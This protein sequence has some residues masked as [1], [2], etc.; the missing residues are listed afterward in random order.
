MEEVKGVVQ[1]NPLNLFL[2][3]SVAGTGHYYPVRPYEAAGS[4]IGLR[5]HIC[6]SRS[7]HPQASLGISK[8]P[9]IEGT[10]QAIT[11]T[12]SHLDRCSFQGVIM[13][14]T[15]F[16]RSIVHSAKTGRTGLPIWPLRLA[17]ARNLRRRSL[18]SS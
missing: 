18:A 13:M 6:S 2:T 8:R 7:L 15:P 3:S 12:I 11:P 9:Q 16:S 17:P 14:I 1:Y 10:S 4:L 5:M